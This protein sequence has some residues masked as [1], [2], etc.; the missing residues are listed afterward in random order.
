MISFS[1]Q[2]SEAVR[3]RKDLIDEVFRRSV[4]DVAGAAQTPGPSK[5]N[6]DG[7][8]GG[9]MPIGET[10]FLRA[11]LVAVLGPTAPPTRENDSG[12]KFSFD[13]GAI[14]LVIAGATVDD[15]VTLAWTARYA[16]YVHRRYQ[17]A[18]LAAQQWNSLVAKNAA[19]VARE[20]GL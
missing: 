13:P 1:A 18:A 11:S 4:Q 17:W 7:G 8:R 19:E 14:N 10:G 20:A 5:F 16:R 9:H 2:V 3:K 15:T 6:P 12:A